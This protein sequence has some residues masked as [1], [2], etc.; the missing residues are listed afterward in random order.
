MAIS[1]RLRNPGARP[2]RPSPG[3]LAPVPAAKLRPSCQE[4]RGAQLHALLVEVVAL[5]AQLLGDLVRVDVVLVDDLAQ[6]VGMLHDL[7]DGVDGVRRDGADGEARDYGDHEHGEG[8]RA[9][10]HACHLLVHGAAGGGR[11]GEGHDK[12]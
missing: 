9:H 8:A 4:V 7:V 11:L 6:V 10:E 2:A 1:S 5:L 12:R 3:L